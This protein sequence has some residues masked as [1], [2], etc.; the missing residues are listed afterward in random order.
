M[1]SSQ[2]RASVAR[3]H[4]ISVEAELLACIALGIAEILESLHQLRQFAPSIIDGLN[5]LSSMAR[6][7]T[8]QHRLQG[9]ASDFPQEARDTKEVAMKQA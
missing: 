1:N 2:L 8:G 9:T 5:S 3:F 7:P 6:I 4:L